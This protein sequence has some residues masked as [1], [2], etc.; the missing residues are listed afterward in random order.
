MNVTL[1]HWAQHLLEFFVLIPACYFAAVPMEDKF[2][3]SERTTWV[4]MSAAILLFSAAGAWICTEHGLETNDILMPGLILFFILYVHYI[5]EGFGQKMFCFAN[6]AM[7]GAFATTYT[8]YLMAPLEM[9]EEYHLAFSLQ[10]GLMALLLDLLLGIIFYRT[11][12]IKLP[13][14]LRDERLERLWRW[15]PIIPV[16]MTSV[17]Y[18]CAPE[19]LDLV[20]SGKVRQIALVMLTLVPIV[21]WVLYD[22]FWQVFVLLTESETLERQNTF[23]QVER[24]RY[25]ALRKMIDDTRTIRHDF[26]QH[27]RVIGQ[28]AQ[29]GNLDKLLA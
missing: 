22:I 9:K 6:A 15:L 4:A 29:E 27:M 21:M 18:W 10:S 14:I 19:D 8:C 1:L 13:R 26:R 12:K 2:R 7:V 23:F 5:N 17:L 20:M 24:R 16:V 11:L 3:Y 28:M 25:D